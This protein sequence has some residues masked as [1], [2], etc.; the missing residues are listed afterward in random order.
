MLSFES[1]LICMK[2]PVIYQMIVR[3][4]SNNNTTNRCDGSMEENGCGKFN[5]I[6]FKALEEIKKM[7]F[8]HVWFTGVLEHSTTTAAVGRAA[9]PACVVK[10]KAG[11]P[12]AIR[13]YYDVA[14]ELSENQ[15]ERIAEFEALILRTHSS[16][17]KAI[18]D[19]VPN[20]LARTYHSDMKPAGITDFGQSDDPTKPFHPQNNFYYLPTE[21]LRLP[22]SGNSCTYS[23][24][25]AKATGNDC[26]TAAP[27]I[28]DWYETVK[29]N[30]GLDYQ[31]GHAE[32]FEPVPDTWLKMNHIL[33][34]WAEKGIDGFRCDMASMVP[35][36]FWSQ[37]IATVKSRFPHIQFIAEIYEPW[38]YAEYIN[39]GGF[40]Y[41]YDKVGLYDTL[42]AVV[43]RQA[44]A[45]QISH[46]WRSIE[47]LGDHM[48]NF[49]ENHDEQRIASL[50]FAGTP[51]AG[52]PAFT[53]AALMNRGSV[54]LYNGQEAGEDGSLPLGHSGDD[55]RTSIFDYG[56]MPSLTRWVNGN[57]DSDRFDTESQS[58]RNTYSAIIQLVN[59]FDAFRLGSFYDLMWVNHQGTGF[60]DNHVYVFLRHH[61]KEVM[62]VAANFSPE[63]R[64]AD[65]CIPNHA[66]RL[67][68][69]WVQ[70]PATIASVTDTRKI[71]A[72]PDLAG[73]LHA[74]I[75]LEGFGIFIGKIRNS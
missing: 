34:Y 38:L 22:T 12:Y 74:T 50:H 72:V 73:D 27:G 43:T 75:S 52:I 42:R 70:G 35:V 55:G 31:N 11:S 15:D 5:H 13:D 53:V 24:Y 9:D 58:L 69:L 8:T 48:L 59:S 4:F 25:P 19:F 1:K 37:A 32:H 44:P 39:R 63:N 33:S 36:A 61:D 46:C 29:L 26:F 16:G 54:L 7:G 71:T 60:P 2:R 14:A 18:I 40:D 56:S 57:F 64:S 30:Y 66:I 62:L 20:H 45:G 41:L 21:P 67:T 47:G 51:L 49:I 65:T 68:G 3:L 10:G 6:T 23:E 28:N 17:L